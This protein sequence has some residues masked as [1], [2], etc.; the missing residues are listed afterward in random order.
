MKKNKIAAVFKDFALSAIIITAVFFV[1]I[2]LFNY[3]YIVDLIPAVCILGVFLI[4]VFT[5]AYIWGIAASVG[6]VILVDYYSVKPSLILGPFSLESTI[7][8]IIM[9]SIAI[10]TSTLTA[11]IKHEKK[12]RKEAYAERMRANLMRAVGHDLRTPLTA[13][14]ASAAAISENYDSLSFEQRMDL[15]R[16]IQQES[17]GLVRMVENILLVTRINQDG[18]NIVKKAAVLEEL[19]DSVLVKFNKHFPD[20]KVNVDIPEEFVSIP[21][22]VILIEQVLTNLMENAVDHAKGMTEI[23]FRVSTNGKKALF[24]VSDDG[25]GIAKEK[26]ERIFD[27]YFSSIHTSHHNERRN[28]GIGLS[29]CAAIIAAHNGKIYAKNNRSGGVGFYFSLN[30]EE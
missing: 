28:M 2:I 20:V 5:K 8:A 27:G 12:I 6:S 18:V 10:I 11:R 17:D 21:M 24:E 22:D 4:S 19:V 23:T 3:A 29:V 25:C 1:N 9:F 16:D 7:T 14:H 13:I 15:V 30:M 26:I